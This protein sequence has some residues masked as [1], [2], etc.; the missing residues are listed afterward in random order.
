MT[1]PLALQ[2]LEGQVLRLR[3]VVDRIGG[4]HQQG[5]IQHTLCLR[6]LEVAASGQPIT[7][8]HWWFRLRQCWSELGLQ[9][10]DTLLFT[11]KVRCRSKGCHEPDTSA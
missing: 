9:A 4:F 5:R 1:T 7:P 3:G 8:D 10:G 6:N 2:G 11:V